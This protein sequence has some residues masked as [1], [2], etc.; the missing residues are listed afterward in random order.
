MLLELDARVSFRILLS[1]LSIG[2]NTSLI[3]LCTFNI[4]L[5]NIPSHCYVL[6]SVNKVVA[7]LLTYLQSPVFTLTVILL[8]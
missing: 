5:F 8:P 7:Y 1:V 4:Y 6:P 3:S 2:F